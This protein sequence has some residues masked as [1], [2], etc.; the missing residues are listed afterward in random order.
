MDRSTVQSGNAG[1]HGKS[2][3][4]VCQQQCAQCFTA[5]TSFHSTYEYDFR[6]QNYVQSHKFQITEQ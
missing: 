4:M 2:Q 5:S 3:N 6:P 1:H